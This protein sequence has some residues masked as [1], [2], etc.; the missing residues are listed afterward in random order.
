[1]LNTLLP[2]V[3]AWWLGLAGLFVGLRR[4]RRS[5]LAFGLLLAEL[6]FIALFGTWERERFRTPLYPLELML[7]AA[8]LVWLVLAAWRLA[9]SVRERR[10]PGLA[11]SGR[12]ALVAGGATLL[13]ALLA[14]RALGSEKVVA[15]SPVDRPSDLLAW[16]MLQGTEATVRIDDTEAARWPGSLWLTTNPDGGWQDLQLRMPAAS[17]QPN[18]IYRIA[19]DGRTDGRVA[20]Q[21]YPLIPADGEAERTV[22]LDRYEFSGTEWDE[23]QHFFFAPFDNRHDLAVYVSHADYRVPDANVWVD[24]LTVTQS[25]WARLVWEG[26]VRGSW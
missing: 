21:V 23:H 4:P 19:F 22:G 20:G 12:I 6:A 10:R 9:G 11:L 17:Y 3:V 7:V 26:Y 16:Q 1:L 13:L 15:F 5:A 2:G 8:G 18:G 24:D 25:G 14:V